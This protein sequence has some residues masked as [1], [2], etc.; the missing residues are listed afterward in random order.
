[1]S[2]IKLEGVGRLCGL[3]LPLVKDMSDTVTMSCAVPDT[4]VNI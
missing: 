1:M 2:F 3:P 4:I